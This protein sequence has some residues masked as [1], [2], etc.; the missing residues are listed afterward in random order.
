MG[1]DDFIN[2]LDKEEQQEI[3]SAYMGEPI[4]Y[5]AKHDFLDYISDYVKCDNCKKWCPEY[6]VDWIYEE[7]ICE[8]C[9]DDG[10][11]IE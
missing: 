11:P 8:S 3:Y 7:R 6:Y 4:E 5:R 1:I 2:E 9:R 10:Y